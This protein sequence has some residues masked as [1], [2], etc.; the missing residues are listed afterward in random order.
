MNTEVM[1]V[2]HSIH[3]GYC[4]SHTVTYERGPELQ[5]YF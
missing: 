3:Q 4:V 2:F 5:I 1:A